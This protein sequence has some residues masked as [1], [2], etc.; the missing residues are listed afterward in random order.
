MRGDQFGGLFDDL[1]HLVA[2]FGLLEVEQDVRNF[3][4][5]VAGKLVCGDSV[6]EGRCLLVVEDSVKFRF[7]LLD[8]LLDRRDIVGKL[9]LVERRDAVRSVPFLQERVLVLCTGCHHHD[10]SQS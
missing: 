10:C 5:D 1:V 8:S 9:D 3:V 2:A 6:L 4:Q 7:L